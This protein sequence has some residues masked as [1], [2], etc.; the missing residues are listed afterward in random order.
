MNLKSLEPKSDELIR[1]FWFPENSDDATGFTVRLQYLSPEVLADLQE[2]IKVR[3]G[4]P[5][6]SANVS[7]VELRRGIVNELLLSAVVKCEGVNLGKLCR[8]IPLAASKVAS[9]G[10][11]ATAV[12]M[13]PAAQGKSEE[14]RENLLHLLNSCDKFATWAL[15]TC[16]DISKFQSDDWEAEVKNLSGLGT[17]G[18]KTQS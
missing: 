4:N 12:D 5:A 8:L 15:Q 1:T 16:Q 7:P 14:A 10:G 17:S 6:A 2:K 9:A 3:R 11:L 18:E 13:D